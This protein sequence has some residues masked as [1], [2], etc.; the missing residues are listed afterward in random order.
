MLPNAPTYTELRLK[1]QIKMKTQT[2]TGPIKYHI[3]RLSLKTV[4]NL[5]RNVIK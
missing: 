4:A 2:I 5:F 1:D 3:Y